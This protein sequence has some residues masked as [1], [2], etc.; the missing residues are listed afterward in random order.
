MAKIFVDHPNKTIQGTLEEP[1]SFEDVKEYGIRMKSLAV[2]LTT[3]RVILI[4][5]DKEVMIIEQW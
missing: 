4:T 1:E 2:L 3:Y 5:K